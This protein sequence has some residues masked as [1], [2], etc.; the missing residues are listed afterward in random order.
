MPAPRAR[1][2]GEG[3]PGYASWPLHT[4]EASFLV[5]YSFDEDKVVCLSIR[6]IPAGVY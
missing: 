2:G 6:E 5:V 3:R 1:D 4:S